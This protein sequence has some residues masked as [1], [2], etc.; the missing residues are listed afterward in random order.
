[1]DQNYIG[2]FSWR[3]ELENGEVGAWGGGGGGGGR[4]TGRGEVLGHV[5]LARILAL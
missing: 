3:G 1:M 5:I 4:E 2:K